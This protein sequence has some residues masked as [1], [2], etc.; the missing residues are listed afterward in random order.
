MRAKISPE[1]TAENDPGRQSWVRP[2]RKRMLTGN[3][4]ANPI[5]SETS[6]VPHNQWITCTSSPIRSR[7]FD[8]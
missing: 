3:H 4:Q 6:P 5:L 8:S 1:G 2:D 7:I